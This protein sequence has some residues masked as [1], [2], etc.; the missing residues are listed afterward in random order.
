MARERAGIRLSREDSSSR[1]RRLFAALGIKNL[2][3]IGIGV[4]VIAIAVGGY[5]WWSTPVI[6][7]ALVADASFSV[8]APRKAPSGY[9][10]QESRT[11]LSSDTL[12]YAFRDAQANRDIVVTVQPLPSGFDMTQMTEG[13]SI[14]RITT[15]SGVLY[16]L[17]AGGA[18]KYLLSTGD[19]LIF[20]TS[21]TA[22]D[23]ATISSI[24]DD[25]V[26]LN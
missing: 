1:L 5:I 19:S 2:L 10:I 6:D 9:V 15:S 20:L 24:A 25:L 17:S 18:S 23:T 12:T 14:D 13:G 26:K 3:R 8:Y 22:I 7:K 16:N 4:I 11:R 21:S